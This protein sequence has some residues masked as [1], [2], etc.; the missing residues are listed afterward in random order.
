M[1]AARRI[2]SAL[3]GAKLAVIAGAGHM[4]MLERPKEFNARLK[5][6]VARIPPSSGSPGAA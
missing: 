4:S 5:A 2:A 1:R 3:P 6:F